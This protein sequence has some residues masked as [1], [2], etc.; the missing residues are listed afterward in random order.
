MYGGSTWCLIIGGSL[1]LVSCTRKVDCE[2]FCAREVQCAAEI[3]VAQRAATAE[4]VE[5]L[6]PDDRR[7][8]AERQAKRCRPNCKSPTMPGS[9]HTKW[10]RCLDLA[11]CTAF[12]SCVYH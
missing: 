8:L 1:C 4:Q 9:V 5:G 2:A 12:A 6:G 3:A 7:V 10:R 11:D